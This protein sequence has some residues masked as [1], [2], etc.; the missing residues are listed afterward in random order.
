MEEHK[1]LLEDL[2]WNPRFAA[3][4]EPYSEQGMSPARVTFEGRSA[5]K[6]M[7]ESG[8]VSAVPAGKLLHASDG[9][10]DLPVVGDWVAAQVLDE[11][12]RRAVIHAVL[13]R[14]SVFARKEAGDR[15][16]QQPVAAN[17][18]T[19]FITMGLDGDFSL[20]RIERYLTLAWESSALPVVL[21]TK[22]DLCAEVEASVAAVEGIAPGVR[23]HAVSTFKKT[24]LDQLDEYLLPGRTVAFLGSSGVGKS[25]IINHLLG[26]DTQQVR[27]VRE[28]DS[29][30]RHTTTSRQIFATPSGALVVDT[31]GMRELQLWNAS[32]GLG[33]A[34]SDIE[35]IALDCRYRD[36]RHEGE[37]GCAVQAAIESG[38]L[39]LSRMENYRKMLRELHHLEVKQSQSAEQVEPRGGRR[40]RRR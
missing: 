13:P 37:P 10:G 15:V 7:C 23:V 21:L 4:F 16:R 19:V 38:L 34:F 40:G 2:G 6:V 31:P 1:L 29:M 36:C 11:S 9:R 39:D 25:T 32:G 22:A 26:S 12:P 35:E 18:D 28:D 24:G 17:I 8:Q 14:Q 27:E 3:Y 30:G 5:Y 20:R 33:A